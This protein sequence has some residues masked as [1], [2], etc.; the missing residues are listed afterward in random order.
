MGLHEAGRKWKE[1]PQSMLRAAIQ[2]KGDLFGSHLSARV[3][4]TIIMVHTNI[5]KKHK[6]KKLQHLILIC[7]S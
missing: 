4:T 5:K 3:G 7:L 6:G 2:E 1:M